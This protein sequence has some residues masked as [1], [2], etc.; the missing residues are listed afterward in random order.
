M[1]ELLKARGITISDMNKKFIILVHNRP[2]DNTPGLY[3]IYK[4][5]SLIFAI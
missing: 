5:I 2:G 1:K 4:T 3:I